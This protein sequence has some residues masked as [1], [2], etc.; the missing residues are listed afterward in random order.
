MK[1]IGIIM[2]HGAGNKKLLKVLTRPPLISRPRLIQFH[3]ETLNENFCVVIVRSGVGKP[4]CRSL[5][6]EFGRPFS[7][8]CHHQ[9]TG[10]AGSRNAALDIGIF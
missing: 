8:H 5:C 10:V 1:K 9:H 7:G 6:V 2:C 3:E 4:Q